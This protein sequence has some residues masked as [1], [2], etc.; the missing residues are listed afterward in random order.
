VAIQ[1]ATKTE[2]DFGQTCRLNSA[3]KCIN[4]DQ[5]RIQNLEA[6]NRHLRMEKDILKIAIGLE[7]SAEMM[8]EFT[9][10]GK[11]DIEILVS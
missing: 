2:L 5:K 11:R 8:I 10:K 1:G 3:P 7:F 4:I 6:E 9:S